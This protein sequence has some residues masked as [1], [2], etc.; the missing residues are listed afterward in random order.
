MVDLKNNAHLIPE[1]IKNL[2]TRLNKVNP[3]TNEYTM[4]V[5]QLETVKEYITQELDK[6]GI[7]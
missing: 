6:K 4:V 7:K 1:L 3:T 5:S 2:V